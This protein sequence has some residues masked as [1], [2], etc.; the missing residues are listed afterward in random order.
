MR[1]VSA[2][3]WS[4]DNFLLCVAVLSA[5]VDRV[6]RDSK[7][8]PFSWDAEVWIGRPSYSG[9]RSLSLARSARRNAI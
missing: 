1:T 5:S 2:Y 7:E 3:L 8:I 4:F 6:D 9:Q